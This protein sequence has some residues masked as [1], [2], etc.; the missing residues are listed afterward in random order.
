M[1]QE[2]LSL[3]YEQSRDTSDQ[4]LLED[5]DK[6]HYDKA[7]SVEDT[8]ANNGIAPS[9]SRRESKTTSHRSQSSLGLPVGDSSDVLDLED[10]TMETTDA[11]SLQWKKMATA[12]RRQSVKC[13]A[14]RGQEKRPDLKFQTV[15]LLKESRV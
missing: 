8:G 6:C 1:L 3:P 5:Q 14:G 10:K 4:K 12:L 15:Y 13:R 2:D 7:N 11:D 9:D